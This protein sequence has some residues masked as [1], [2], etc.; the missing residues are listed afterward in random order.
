MLPAQRTHCASQD[1]LRQRCGF[2]WMALA[3]PKRWLPQFPRPRGTRSCALVQGKPRAADFA[4]IDSLAD[5]I[6]ERH[7]QLAY[8]SLTFSMG[9]W[10]PC[11]EIRR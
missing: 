8:S 6:A 3:P 11:E 9:C 1:A 4:A 10:V 2:L 7:Q 5:A